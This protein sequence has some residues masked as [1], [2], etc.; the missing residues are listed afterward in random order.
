MVSRLNMYAF[1]MFCSVNRPVG[2]S[3]VSDSEH[4]HDVEF[5]V[6]LVSPH[7]WSREVRVV[8][9]LSTTLGPSHGLGLGVSVDHSRVCMEGKLK[10]DKL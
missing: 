7:S 4:A 2:T 6:V 1:R 8:Q 10:L 9:E 3:L 5:A